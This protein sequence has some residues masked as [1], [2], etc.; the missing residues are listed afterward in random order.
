MIVSKLWFLSYADRFTGKNMTNF[1]EVFEALINK[2]QTSQGDLAKLADLTPSYISHLILGSRTNPSVK[3]LIKLAKALGLDN[4]DKKLLFE[5]AGVPLPSFPITTTPSIP[6]TPRLVDRLAGDNTNEDWGDAPNVQA[7]YGREDELE[8]LRSWILH[9]RCQL[10]IVAGAGGIGKTMLTTRL[11][12]DIAGEFDYVFW[13]SLKDAPPFENILEECLQLFSNQQSSSPHLTRDERSRQLLSYLKAHR[14]LLV[15]DNIDSI[16]K[17]KEHEGEYSNQYEEYG[18]L[19]D[20]IGR[21]QHQSCLIV[22]TRELPKGITLLAGKTGPV[23]VFPLTGLK[24][25][26]GLKILEDKGL[27]WE[28]QVDA[29]QELVQ[30]YSGNPLALKVAAEFI[31]G[32]FAGDIAL[33]LSRGYIAFHDIERVLEEQFERLASLEQQVMYW[34]AIDR[35]AISIQDLLNELASPPDVMTLGNSLNALKRRSLVEVNQNAFT[36]QPVILEF[37]IRMFVTRVVDEID[38]G[39]VNLFESHAFIK[40][41]TKDYIRDAQIRLILDQLAQRLQ[42]KYG[43]DGCEEKLK[44][45]LCKLHEAPPL[46]RG[47]AAGNLLNLLSHM[48]YDLSNYDFSHLYVWQAYLQVISLNYVNFSNAHFENTIFTDTFTSIL[49]VAFSPDDALLAAGTENGDIRLI[50]TISGASLR[51]YQGHTGRVRSVAFSPDGQYIV[52]GSEDYKLR[53]W[54]IDTDQCLKILEGHD[55]R[56]RAVAISPDGKTIISGSDDRTVRIWNWQTAKTVRILQEHTD[57]VR[58][59]AISPDGMTIASGGEDQTI[60]IWDLESGQCL[61]ILEGH[62]KQIHAVNFSPDGKLLVSSGEE[63]TIRIW[64]ALSGECLKILPGHANQVRS[65]T[66]S[67]S[68]DTVV[69]SSDDT[70][71]RIWDIQSGQVVKTLGGHLH[72][73]YSATFSHDGTTI[74]SGSEDQTIRLW[75]VASGRSI[76]TLQG[77]VN[78]VRSVAFNPAGI[79]L[80]SGGDDRQIRVWDVETGQRMKVLRDHTNGIRSVAFSPDG[81]KMASGGDDWT[82]RLWN[83]HSWRCYKVLRDHTDRVRTIAFNHDGTRLASGGEDHSVRIWD[84]TSGMRFKVLQGHSDWIRSVAF[85]PDDTLLVSAGEDCTVRVWDVASDICLKILEGHK[86]GVR[87]VAF[88]PDGSILASSG[89]DETIRLWDTANW[90]QLKILQ[91]D[92]NTRIY[93]IISIAFS[94]NGALLAS[95]GEDKAVRIWDVKS[96]KC[97]RTMSDHQH[98]IYAVAFHPD[99]GMLASGSLDG[100][101]KLWEVDTGICIRTLSDNKP[102]EG[103]NITDTEGLTVTQ[104]TMLKALGA[105][106]EV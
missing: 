11:V 13:R 89:D 80:V 94:P 66:F 101:I 102:Y 1:S 82:V 41:S 24:V 105:I 29:A 39:L 54:S 63:Q 79:L 9:E 65:V 64:D 58:T 97:L 28:N 12:R 90:E 62:E 40:A 71:I 32:A 3:T 84:T 2:K 57:K 34:L 18:K 48:K 4:E 73:V 42:N 14:C 88:S 67:P 93:W 5:A 81:E 47:Y 86:N 100:S 99:G 96:G 50:K 95:G 27:N 83:A 26:D 15:L 46:K 17:E 23:R 52:S 10:V 70:S 30:K 6:L 43:R 98:R 44:A 106:E 33:F 7:F 45:I 77:Y 78:Q 37:V 61:R 103:M 87:S 75:D 85:S 38:N 72:R 60:R 35:E 92:E 91:G 25:N 69:S 8:K 22:T 21:S 49:S 76:K 59:V 53:I 20:A 56:V 68:G 31:Q 51:N 19:I 36:L 55:D 74:A 16:L 104:R